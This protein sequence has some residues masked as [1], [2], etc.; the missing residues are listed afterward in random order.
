M[1]AMKAKNHREKL[2]ERMVQLFQEGLFVQFRAEPAASL[3]NKRVKVTATFHLPQK[4]S[5]TSLRPVVKLQGSTK[6][7]VRLQ[8]DLS[9]NRAV[10]NFHGD[11]DVSQFGVQ[12][13]EATL[14]LEPEGGAVVARTTVHIFDQADFLKA[15]EELRQH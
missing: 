6:P 1:R 3:G 4:M 7:G 13:G 15:Q 10:R 9:S 11:L 5:L 8:E 2:A 14:T 12:S